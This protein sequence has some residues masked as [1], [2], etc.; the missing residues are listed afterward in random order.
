MN[1][2]TYLQRRQK[3]KTSKLAIAGPSCKSREGIGE[4]EERRKGDKECRRLQN[5][6]PMCLWCK[7]VTVLN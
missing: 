1:C 5:W 2:A 3:P 4:K 7:F 6:P